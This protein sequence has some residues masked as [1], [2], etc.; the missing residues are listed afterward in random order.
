[1]KNIQTLAA[2]YALLAVGL[3]AFGAHA[4]NDLLLGNNMASVWKT[5]V[6]YQM[7]HALAVLVISALRLQ[8]RCLQYS[9]YS[10]ALGIF[11]FSGSLYG[12]ALG[13][14]KWLGPITPI[15]GTLLIAGWA[16][17]IISLLKNKNNL[18]DECD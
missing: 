1:M 2:T 9:L 15:G 4:L 6:E 14:P 5:A 11:I 16:L 17:L 18:E 8:G 13:G 12:L 3:G 10:F 7:W